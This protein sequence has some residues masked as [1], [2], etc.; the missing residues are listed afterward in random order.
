MLNQTH[1]EGVLFTFWSRKARYIIG[2]LTLCD[3]KERIDNI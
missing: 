1:F 3:V 2:D